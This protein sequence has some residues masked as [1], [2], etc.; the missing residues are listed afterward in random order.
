[1]L[2]GEKA[3]LREKNITD[4]MD[5]YTWRSDSDLARYD[6]VPSLKLSSQE[7]MLYYADEL[8]NSDRIKR[9]YAIDTPEGKHIGNCMYYDVDEDSRQA[10]L[11]IMIGDREYWSKGYGTD[12]VN[13]LVNHIFDTTDL[14]RIYL[15]TLEWNVRAQRCFRKCGFIACGRATRRGND[16]LIMELHRS[17]LRRAETDAA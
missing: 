12:A 11:G 9:W 8:R 5:D 6:G 4:A 14:D 2:T 17:W 15:D 7:F 13:A 16:F 1:M 10:K 3:V